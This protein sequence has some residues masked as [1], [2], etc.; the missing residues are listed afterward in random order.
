MEATKLIGGLLVAVMGL[1]LANPPDRP[2]TPRMAALEPGPEVHTPVAFQDDWSNLEPKVTDHGKRIGLLER[3]VEALG[4]R[5]VDLVNRM[6]TFED[7]AREADLVETPKTSTE[8]AQP[9]IVESY[10]PY[11]EPPP[12]SVAPANTGPV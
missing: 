11:Y 9:I 3:D 5:F 6:N 7:K 10:R 4:N 1:S 8:P 2:T 12:V